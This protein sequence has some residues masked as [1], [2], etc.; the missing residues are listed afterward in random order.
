MESERKI[1]IRKR[2]LISTGKKKK[3]HIVD[4]VENGTVHV[5]C[6]AQIYEEEVVERI[7]PSLAAKGRLCKRCQAYFNKWNAAKR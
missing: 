7:S 3:L 2:D 1:R 5:L 6:L 4:E